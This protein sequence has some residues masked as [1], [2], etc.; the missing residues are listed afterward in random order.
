[1]RDAHAERV[2]SSRAN[3]GISNEVFTIEASFNG[4]S[5]SICCL[6]G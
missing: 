2:T 3:T 1:M 5:E 6:R 4:D